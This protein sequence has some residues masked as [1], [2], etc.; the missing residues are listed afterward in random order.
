M[1]FRE[2]MDGQPFGDPNA[3]PSDET[4]PGYRLRRI[5]PGEWVAEPAQWLRAAVLIGAIGLVVGALIGAFAARSYYHRSAT[6]LLLTVNGK[7]LRQDELRAMLEHRYGIREVIRFAGAELLQQFAAARGCWPTDEELRVRF[8]KARTDPNF[9]EVLALRGLTD[10][11][12]MEELR[13]D[14]A[15][16][17]LLTKGITVTDAEVRAFYDRNADPANQAARYFQPNRVQVNAIGTD[18]QVAAEQARKDLAAGASW[19]LVAARYSEDPSGSIG[20]L[21]PPFARGESV[22]ATNPETE[23]TIFTMR[24]GERIGPVA[25]ARKWWVI[26]CVAK[27][28]QRTTPWSEAKED[29]RTG[30]ML[31]RGIQ[32]NRARLDHE[33]E[34]FVKTSSIRVFEDAYGGAQEP[35]LSRPVRW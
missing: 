10:D 4:P 16:T 25:A 22:F 29:A 17:K 34:R 26:R 28:G 24:P 30:A 3:R 1:R 12:Y 11:A 19:E 18:T 5:G 35:I 23:R 27:W 13:L 31:V 15:Q 8:E 2:P 21:M 33:L 7:P 14:M 9:Q 20:G 6:G 32:K